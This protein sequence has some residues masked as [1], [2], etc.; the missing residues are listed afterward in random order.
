MNKVQAIISFWHNVT[1]LPVYD[2]NSVPDEARMPYVTCE[3]N[4]ASFEND[5]PLTANLWYRD[6][7]WEA[8]SL[9]AE[10]ISKALFELR[11]TAQKINDGRF[12]V[13]EGTSPLCQRLPDDND[14]M[15]KRIVINVMVEFMTNY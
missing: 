5:I 6:T 9:K 2:E 13:Y 7:S 11:G 1:G 15:V 3:I 10:A 4:T 12:R 8:I 14:D